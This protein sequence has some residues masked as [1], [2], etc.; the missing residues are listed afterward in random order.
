MF[1]FHFK[2]ALAWSFKDTAVFV[3]KPMN[4]WSEEKE[5]GFLCLL[6]EFPVEDGGRTGPLT[7]LVCAAITK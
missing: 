7:L 4:A 5:P 3:Q 6:L 2:I 1:K